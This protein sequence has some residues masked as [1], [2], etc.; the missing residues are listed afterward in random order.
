MR[1][2]RDATLPARPLIIP[3]LQVNMRA[4]QMPFPED[5]GASYLKVPLNRVQVPRGTLT[6]CPA[7]R[8]LK[9]CHNLTDRSP[10]GPAPVDP[11]PRRRAPDRP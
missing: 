6:P 4:G 2:R 3:S 10:H 5:N 7:L 1:E 8:H 11:R 9:P